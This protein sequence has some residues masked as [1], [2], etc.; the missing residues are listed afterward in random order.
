MGVRKKK[1]KE[2]RSPPDPAFRAAGCSAF[3]Q[4]KRP[5][6]YR[7]SAIIQI[8]NNPIK[9]KKLPSILPYQNS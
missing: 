1:K 2:L 7:I 5:L 4:K 9:K 6:L 8:L 3:F